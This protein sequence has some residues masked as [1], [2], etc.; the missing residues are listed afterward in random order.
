MTLSQ[1]TAKSALF[2][3]SQRGENSETSRRTKILLPFPLFSASLSCFSILPSLFFTSLILNNKSS[4]NQGSRQPPPSWA[5]LPIP[6][7]H[8]V[9]HLTPGRPGPKPCRGP[10]EPQPAP[11]PS[12]MAPRH[13]PKAR[14]TYAL[15][16][17]PHVAALLIRGEVSVPAH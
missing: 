11:F 10:G 14:G 7:S 16:V 1:I 9:R 12:P 6:S 2:P 15:V 17:P 4:L 13:R 5:I 8:G 3:I